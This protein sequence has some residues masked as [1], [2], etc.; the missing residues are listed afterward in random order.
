MV[1]IINVFN[2]EL[3]LPIETPALTKRHIKQN[4]KSENKIYNVRVHV[5]SLF[6]LRYQTRRNSPEGIQVH[7]LFPTLVLVRTDQ[8]QSTRQSRVTQN[9]THEPHFSGW[10]PH[11]TQPLRHYIIK[12]CF[13]FWSPLLLFHMCS[14]GNSL[15][16]WCISMSRWQKSVGLKKK[17]PSNHV[18]VPVRN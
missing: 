8:A 12:C 14:A 7:L 3:S 15:P 10:K 4:M 1:Y 5:L 9:T 11:P 16:D 18:C 17:K 6:A 13:A 2:S